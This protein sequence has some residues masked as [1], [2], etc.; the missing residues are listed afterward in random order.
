MS[1]AGNNPKWSWIG[2]EL[3]SQLRSALAQMDAT[4]AESPFLEN[5]L[6]LD[7]AGLENVYT[8]DQI[9]AELVRVPEVL[10][11]CV[12]AVEEENKFIMENHARRI[13]MQSK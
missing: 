8:P 7:K 12:K 4:V 13:K 3:L 6:C 10:D 9:A 11:A 1:Q 5:F 2:A